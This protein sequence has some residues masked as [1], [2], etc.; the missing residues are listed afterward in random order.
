[1]MRFY[2]SQQIIVQSRREQT[3]VQQQDLFLSE[4]VFTRGLH[5]R[6]C[7]CGRGLFLKPAYEAG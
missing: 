3:R 7:N 6:M 4:F 1:M 2:K 5:V